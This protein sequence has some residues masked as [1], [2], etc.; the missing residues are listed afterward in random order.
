VV[1]V[2]EG[3]G[4]VTMDD[5]L[6][7]VDA[8][9]LAWYPGVRGGAAIAR[10]L[11][12]EVNPSARLPL[13]FPRAEADLPPFDNVSPSVTYGYF[14]GYR[15]LDH[16]GIAPL[17]PFG[18]GL[19][20][21]EYSYSGLRLDGTTLQAGDVLRATVDVSNSGSRPGRETVQLYVGAVTSTVAPR[22][23]RELRGFAQVDLEPGETK[24]ATIEVPVDDLSVYDAALAAFRVEPGTY[25][26]EVGPSS[27]DLPLATE[28][29][30]VP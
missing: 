18:F 14:H 16:E 9:L 7:Q 10:V 23:V 3:G 1:V 27:R 30:V 12:G 11:F 29:T 8:V 4:A 2:V 5:F 20:Y 26:V 24:A 21:T 13:S 28:V 6:G 19:S 22:F 15:H 25:R 17:F